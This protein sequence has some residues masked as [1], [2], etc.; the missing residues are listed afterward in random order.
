MAQASVADTSF[1][2]MAPRPVASAV[3]PVEEKPAPV[4]RDEEYAT[5][6]RQENETEMTSPISKVAK[7][8]TSGDTA[9][10]QDPRGGLLSRLRN[11]GSL[12]TS[13]SS[14]A[15]PSAAESADMETS[16][17]AAEASPPEVVATADAAASNECDDDDD[18]GF[19]LIESLPTA[20]GHGA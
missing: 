19:I 8:S 15:K 4:S 10:V 17:R 20:A 5:S 7:V 11:G 9:P 6:P 1:I 14:V 2:A 13:A 16:G 3:A 18:C 12:V